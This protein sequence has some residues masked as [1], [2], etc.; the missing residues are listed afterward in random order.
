MTE[1]N[2]YM[3]PN[4]ELQGNTE[5]P[6]GVLLT[7][8]RTV[9]G[10]R[11][12][13]WIVKGYAS[14]SRNPGVWT[15]IL[16]SFMFLG[17]LISL[18]PILGA[19]VW[20]VIGYIFEG[21][22]MMGCKAQDD[23]RSLKINHLFY[24][25]SD[26]G[27]LAILGLLKIVVFIVLLIALLVPFF[28]LFGLSASGVENLVNNVFG[29]SGVALI[30]VSGILFVVFI[31]PL[32]MMFWFAPCLIALNKIPAVEAMKISFTGCLKN[33]R[34]FFVY[35][36][37]GFGLFVLVLVISGALAQINSSLAMVGILAIVLVGGP[38][39]FSSIYHSYKD[40]FIE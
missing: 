34:S 3:T 2:P 19:L 4:A 20:Y 11:G 5:T 17:G 12:W 1:N 32:M 38:I 29:D 18:I 27:E 23:G 26:G 15:S 40:I 39:G 37:A 14:F 7:Q 36:L 22:I 10:E 16:L 35:G 24:S 13:Q 33:V 31:L 9:T 21:G 25:F 30:V 28:M 8:P 6:A